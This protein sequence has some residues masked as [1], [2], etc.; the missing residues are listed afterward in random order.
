MKLHLLIACAVTMV[1]M[2]AWA[3]HPIPVVSDDPRVQLPVT[4]GIS[5]ASIDTVERAFQER[6]IHNYQSFRNQ[7]LPSY[8]FV[9]QDG[10]YAGKN[11]TL[12]CRYKNY[13]H[14][15]IFIDGMNNNGFSFASPEDCFSFVYVLYSHLIMGVDVPKAYL[16]WKTGQVVFEDVTYA[17]LKFEQGKLFDTMPSS[18]Y[19]H[20]LPR[21]RKK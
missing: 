16:H 17:Q 21:P 10:A 5:D 13:K 8:T 4:L 1:H 7:D 11:A 14:F 9:I 15:A 12:A 6:G 18:E 3:G 19:A 2:T 20:V